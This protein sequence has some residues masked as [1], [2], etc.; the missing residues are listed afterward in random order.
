MNLKSLTRKGVRQLADSPQ[1]F[2]R[3]EEYYESGAIYRFSVSGDGITAK[4]HGNYGDYTVRIQDAGDELDMDC[5]CPYE[6]YV[7]KHIVAVLLRHLEGEHEEI[8]PTDADT[9]GALKQALEAISHKELL[10][11]ILKL[12]DER[13]DFRR[14][15]LA[16]VSIS[17]QI[18]NKQPKDA[19]KVKSL[20]KEISDF[21]NE[22]EYRSEYDYDYYDYEYDEDEEYPELDSVFEVAKTLNPTDQ[23]EVFWHVLSCGN[24]M[25]EDYAIGTEQIEE[26]AALYAE[27]V[28]KL[29]LAHKEVRPYFDSLVGALGWDMCSYGEVSQ[30][31][32]NALEAICTAPEDY[33]YLISKLKRSHHPEANDWVAGYY[34]KLGDEENYLRV[35]QAN[36]K[37]EAQY[38][39]LAQYWKK[40]GDEEK[41]VVTLE[42][43][44]SN[45]PKRADEAEFDPFSYARS[46]ETETVLGA[47]EK[48]YRDQK[49]DTNLCRILMTMAKYD[50]IT[51]ALYKQVEKASEKLGKWN[52]FRPALIE[53]A[54]KQ[55]LETLAKI[56]LYEKDWEA[57]IQLARRNTRDEVVQALVADG[58][59]EH[60][61]EESIKIY[62]KL[63][64]SYIDMQ[65]REHYRT[66]ARYADKIK[67]IYLSILGDK[68]S[69]QR[70]I[71]R[72]R[73]NYP[74]HRAL[75]DEFRRL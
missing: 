63:V 57:A 75:Q 1:V 74:R 28:G 73:D 54:K 31:I 38:M 65:S 59:K 29:G 46:E 48:H 17:P 40:K 3:G 53:L 35:R 5:D 69:W 52:E 64:Q 36:L 71:E 58:V 32:K 23:I 41:Y 13:S 55:D 2:E 60:R 11:L 6:G 51:L 47:L 70:Y 43:W 26:A 25:F 34:L 16:N 42:G 37:T 50:E 22:L 4:L 33:L 62:Q 49:D 9:P 66:A 19:K 67:S 24:D 56:Y 7:C 20:K 68:G 12:S 39:E 44:V 30:A 61:P 45:L 27:A 15:L 10:G 18:I 21:F 72:I 8:E 14:M